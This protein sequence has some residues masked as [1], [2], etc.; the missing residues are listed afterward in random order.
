MACSGTSTSPERSVEPA[1]PAPEILEPEQ[2]EAT[3]EETPD[4]A[5]ARCAPQDVS[6][7]THVWKP[8]APR[9]KVCTQEQLDAIVPCALGYGTE[10]ECA[11]FMSG[12]PQADIACARC[13]VTREEASAWGAVVRTPSRE[14]FLNTEGC[15]ALLEPARLPCAKDMHGAQACVKQAC[16]ACFTDPSASNTEKTSCSET[17]AR[18]GCK[19]RVDRD[20]LCTASIQQAASP[21]AVCIV[22]GFSVD[23]FLKIAPVFCGP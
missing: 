4:A 3:S 7:F 13:I 16:S 6:S 12:G 22:D 9:Q 5:S 2:P 10:A 8:P 17:A 11:R 21:A 1:R 14:L 20:V 18:G 23:A 15:V 19:P